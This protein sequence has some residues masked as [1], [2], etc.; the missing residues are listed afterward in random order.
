MKGLVVEDKINRVDSFH[1]R[2][3]H[4][5]VEMLAATGVADANML[6]RTHI[7]RRTAMDQTE[8]FDEIYPEVGKGCLL[9]PETVPES[10]KTMMNYGTV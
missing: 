6:N 4:S 1:N 5:L 2:T 9:N 10:Y 8:R 7:F 3:V